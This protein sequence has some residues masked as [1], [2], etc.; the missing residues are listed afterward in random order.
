MTECINV[1]RATQN[2]ARSLLSCG[3]CPSVCHVDHLM[4]RNDETYYQ[5]G[6]P[7]ILDF[8]KGL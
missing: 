3:A 8:Q 6:G 7:I 2:I 4:Y 5:T 1:Y